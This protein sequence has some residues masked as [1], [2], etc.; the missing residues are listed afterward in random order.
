MKDNHQS[1]IE[2]TS[3]NGDSSIFEDDFEDDND[4]LINLTPLSFNEAMQMNY[5]MQDKT[6]PIFGMI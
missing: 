4:E 2:E 1:A 3:S 6:F 5:C